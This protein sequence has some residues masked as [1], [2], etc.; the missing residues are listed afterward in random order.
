MVFI[1]TLCDSDWDMELVLPTASAETSIEDE[2]VRLIIHNWQDR[3]I[4]NS[5]VNSIWGRGIG[6][7][8]QSI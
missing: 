5:S 8:L 2:E 6:L 1:V 7:Y 3:P 4:F